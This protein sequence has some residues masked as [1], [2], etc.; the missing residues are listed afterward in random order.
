MQRYVALFGVPPH[1]RKSFSLWPDPLFVDK[2]RDVVG[3]S[4]NPSDTALVLCIDE[5][6][7]IQALER[8]PPAIPAGLRH[9]EGVTL[10]SVRHGTT[11]RVA[12]LDV[13][14]GAVVAPCQRR[15]RHQEFL[16]FLARLDASVP[17]DLDG[18]LGI[19]HHAAY[20]HTAVRAWLAARPRY[21]AHFTPTYASWRNQVERWFGLVTQRA[22]R[23]AAVR[24]AA[25][26]VAS[27]LCSRSTPI[28]QWRRAGEALFGPGVCAGRIEHPSSR[29]EHHP[30][31]PPHD[32]MPR[33]ARCRGGACC[34]SA[35]AASVGG[36]PRCGDRA[37]L[38][39]SVTWKGQHPR[40]ARDPRRA[41][42]RPRT[43]HGSAPVKSAS[44]RVDNGVRSRGHRCRRA[45]VHRFSTA[46]THMSP[47]RN[48]SPPL[49]RTRHIARVG[50]APGSAGPTLKRAEA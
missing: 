20:T 3:L 11:T 25:T 36:R 39:A 17:P 15:D 41:A 31:N 6:R 16:A 12:A 10:G 48:T 29:K 26:P 1:R 28:V 18:H 5:R 45:L 8:T 23:G 44:E 13:A 49:V 4:R 22:I 40:S 24:E 38:G 33:P 30:H 46:K 27:G 14:S 34:V 2:G 7:H 42:A 35:R 32:H 21:H 50:S 47:R 9:V 19:D 37:D 43:A